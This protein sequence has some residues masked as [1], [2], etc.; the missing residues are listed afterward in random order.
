MKLGDLLKLTWSDKM[1]NIF[2]AVLFFITCSSASA[3]VVNVVDLNKQII[4]A[5]R[6]T[7]AGGRSIIAVDEND[8]VHEIGANWDGRQG[9]P[10]LVA[11]L[12]ARVLKSGQLELINLMPKGEVPTA[13]R[14]IKL[15]DKVTVHVILTWGFSESPEALTP[16]CRLHVLREENQ[17]VQEIKTEVLGTGLEQFIVEDLTHESA[18]EVLVASSEAEEESMNI[19]QIQK[20]GDVR[21][22]QRI[23]GYRVYTHADKEMIEEATILVEAKGVKGAG[24]GKECSS[25]KEYRWSAAKHKFVDG[26]L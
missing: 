10:F 2:A 24:P 16:F 14:R 9:T 20:N 23:I 3:T 22:I 4:V 18:A 12:G 8:A 11:N 26:N 15:S 7:P 5:E 21:K 6:K 17:A 19:W 13:A 25:I 1:T